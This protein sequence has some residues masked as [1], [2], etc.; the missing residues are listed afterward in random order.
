MCLLTV[1]TV[2]CDAQVVSYVMHNA[3]AMLLSV[4]NKK[5]LCKIVFSMLKYNTGSPCK[6][7]YHLHAS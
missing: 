1:M 4:Q 6:L 7:C 5:N 3:E 2:S